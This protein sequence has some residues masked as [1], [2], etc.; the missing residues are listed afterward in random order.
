M[1]ISQSVAQVYVQCVR[2][3]SNQYLFL[4]VPPDPVKNKS[5]ATVSW[6]LMNRIRGQLQDHQRHLLR[7][8]VQNSN[9]KKC[10]ECREC[11]SF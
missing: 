1:K 6:M 7:E 9:Q 5:E 4:S 2:P 8:Q 11:E 3:S 10:N